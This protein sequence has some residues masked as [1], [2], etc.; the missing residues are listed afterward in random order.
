[1]SSLSL[2]CLTGVPPGLRTFL[3]RLESGDTIGEGEWDKGLEKLALWFTHTHNEF[4]LFTFLNYMNAGGRAYEG[5]LE[6]G[7]L[8][9]VG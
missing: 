4:G 1:M 8:N 6:V 5:V 7:S 9:N 3:E 2:V